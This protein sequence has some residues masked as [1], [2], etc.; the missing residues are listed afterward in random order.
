M[1]ILTIDPVRAAFVLLIFMCGSF[2]HAQTGSPGAP[3]VNQDSLVVGEFENQIKEYLK[4]DKQAQTGIPQLKPTDSA[5]KINQHRR[6]LAGNIR[7]ARAQAKQGD[8]F[9]PEIAQEFK[10]LIAMAYRGGNASQVHA[11]LRHAEPVSDVPV[12]VNAV[13]PEEVP[14][15]STP[16]SILLNLPPLPPELDYRIVGHNLVLRDAGANIIVDYIPG[17]IPSS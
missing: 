4:L 9:S 7:A 14:L 5:S 1:K 3:A 11:S 15:Q 12:K 10:R 13:Y 8:I 6:L 2:L 16:P 17:A